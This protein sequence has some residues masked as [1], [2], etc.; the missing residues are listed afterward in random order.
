M[1]YAS[2]LYTA[3]PVVRTAIYYLHV[4]KDVI[5]CSFAM[6]YVYASYVCFECE[7]KAALPVGRQLR[8]IRVYITNDD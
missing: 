4:E 6:K 2:S 5:V 8:L 1:I 3:S 7:S